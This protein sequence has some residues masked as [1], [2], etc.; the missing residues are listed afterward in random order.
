MTTG[1]ARDLATMSDEKKRQK[2]MEVNF[3][4][5]GK[6]WRC[7]I[8][9]AFYYG[10]EL[11]EVASYRELVRPRQRTVWLRSIPHRFYVI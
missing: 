10:A 9:P 1:E 8:V 4:R 11:E 3:E 5:L 2:C 7:S 6:S